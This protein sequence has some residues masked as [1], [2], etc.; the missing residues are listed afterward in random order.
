MILELGKAGSWRV[1]SVSL[2][3]P[4]RWRHDNANGI[5]GNRFFGQK[6]VIHFRPMILS[7]SARSSLSLTNQKL[8]S[9]QSISSGLHQNLWCKTFLDWPCTKSGA[10][11]C[12]KSCRSPAVCTNV[13]G[14]ISAV[15]YVHAWKT[16]YENLTVN[17][18]SKI[19]QF[20]VFVEYS[21]H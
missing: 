5:A 7:R 6:I 1:V 2:R 20:A 9:A 14:N 12:I 8:L 19:V 18:Y 4:F 10:E 17:D 21:T 11:S 3:P 15:C 13:L 16:E